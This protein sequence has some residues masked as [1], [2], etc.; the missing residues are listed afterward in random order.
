M[1]TDCGY[2]SMIFE[3]KNMLLKTLQ[4]SERLEG[5]N[6][7]L[8]SATAT[9]FPAVEVSEVKKLNT[10]TNINF[11]MISILC[12][13]EGLEREENT[14]LA[15]DVSGALVCEIFKIND[16]VPE[17]FEANH[18]ITNRIHTK[19]GF[20]I[21]SNLIYSLILTKEE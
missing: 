19:N 20:L 15:C 16:Y 7:R 14:K 8:E 2:K 11:L 13:T 6:I 21:R 3:F 17:T 9:D 10:D 4:S 18:V 12:W 1:R 5:V